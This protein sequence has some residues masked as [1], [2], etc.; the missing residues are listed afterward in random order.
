MDQESGARRPGLNRGSLLA[1]SGVRLLTSVSRKLMLLLVKSTPG[2]D[3]KRGAKRYRLT[4]LMNNPASLVPTPVSKRVDSITGSVV[5]F[6]LVVY[7]LFAPVSIAIT[8]SASLLG[9]VA[10]CIRLAARGEFRL[11]RTPIDVAVLGFFACCVVSSFLS[12]DPLVSVKGLKSPAF[13][14]AFYLVS[15]N[16]KTPRFA[17]LLAFA[18]LGSCLISVA[19]SAGQLA[20]GRGLRIDSLSET[21][22]LVNRDLKVGDVILEADDQRV[23]RLSDLAA[24]IISGRG[25]VRLKYQRT[26]AVNSTTVRRQKLKQALT[27][28][29]G[30]GMTTS[31]GR[32]FRVNGF[33]S[34][35]ETY[36]EVLQ[37][38]GALAV[39]MFLAY[40]RKRSGLA[41]FLAFSILLVSAALVMTATRAA[42]A[43]LGIAILATALASAHR[44][45]ILTAVISFLI[46]ASVA[47]L[48][49]ERTRGISVFDPH[50]QSTAWRLEVWRE[51]LG[52]IKDHPVV[53]IG[54]GSEGK[55]KTSLG[56]YDKGR[57]PQSH[58]HSTP[59]QI[60]TWWGLPALVSYFAFMAIL[61]VT[62]LRS[63]RKLKAAGQWNLWGIQLG[64]LG[65]LVAF[66]V[67][68]LVHFNFGDGEVVMVF[69]LLMG[70]AFAVQRMVS[71]ESADLQPTCTPALPAEDS[72]QKSPLLEQA[73]ASEARVRAVKAEHN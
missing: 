49:V 65:A 48:M 39:G 10:W 5:V 1:G 9:L 4:S 15:N 14:F 46:L 40:P 66:N 38:I 42:L 19:F 70:I 35:Y 58:F 60:A 21:S 34:H 64:C 44:R 56:L 20:V 8:Q 47:F 50:E 59:I 36:A 22:P 63:S 3:G 11:A 31:P 52:L 27:S 41:V 61:F 37:L 13:F 33:Y 72:S 29:A 26:E 69:W 17:R 51:A 23:D 68:S 67:S 2:A 62:M 30:L 53:G 12:Y 7:A 6:S 45:A 32:N 28:E 25:A 18:L 54:K 71:Q 16:V 57:L 55:L 43:G 24:I 73:A